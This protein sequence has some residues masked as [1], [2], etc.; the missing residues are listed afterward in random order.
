MT[1]ASILLKRKD[2]ALN[3]LLEI[4]QAI[5]SNMSEHLLYKIYHFTL[6]GNLN[7]SKL[8]LFVFDEKWSYKT[9]FGAKASLENRELPTS[10]FQQKEQIFKIQETSDFQEFD[11]GIKVLHQNKLLAFVLV[12]GTGNEDIDTRFLQTLTN[13]LIVAIENK[14]LAQKEL[15]QEVLQKELE[16]AQKVQ[17]LLFPKELPYSETLQVKAYYSPHSSVGGDYYDFIQLPKHE[18]LF[19]IADVSGKGMGASLMMANFQASLR[20]L[21]RHNSDLKEIVE[22]LN[23]QIYDNARGENFITFFIAK[24]NSNQKTLKYI[25]AGHLPPF[26]Y[27]KNQPMARLELGCTVLG[28]FDPL[29]FINEEVITNVSEFLLFA[30]T[31]GLNETLNVH[32]EQFGEDRIEEFLHANLE[33]NLELLHQNLIRKLDEFRQQLPLVDDITLLS[34]RVC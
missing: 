7:I 12:G 6:R 2:L 25:N 5:N 1:E 22:D 24:Y 19:C 33:Q 15:Q 9:G 30:F 8:A 4:T 32:D 13:I 28:F 34:Y 16:I 10:F 27:R 11:L 3:S 31:D 21:T 23:F 18:Y 26:L 20:T 14:K 29:P 17:M